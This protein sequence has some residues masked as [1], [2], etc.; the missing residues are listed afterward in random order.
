[1]TRF[2]AYASLAA[3]LVPA[4]VLAQCGVRHRAVKAVV[5]K[6][7]LVIAAPVVAVTPVAAFYAVPTL[8]GSIYYPGGTAPVVGAAGAGYGVHAAGPGVS[9]PAA[10]APPTAGLFSDGQKTWIRNE[11]RAAIAEALGKPPAAKGETLPPPMTKADEEPPAEA[12]GGKS[13][14]QVLVSNCLSCHQAGK[15]YR[16]VDEK[17][18]VVRETTFEMFEASGKQRAFTDR[19]WVKILAKTT[20]GLM[21]PPKKSPTTGEDE[22]SMSDKDAAIL[23][24]YIG[25]VIDAK[26]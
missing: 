1:M 20:T 10:P 8:V 18:K 2:L 7:Q 16:Q 13:G 12:K 17:G 14:P 4:P 9:Q 25:K 11:I 15:L 6:E 24:E 22:P 21:P 3:M 26:K 19:Q 23:A 5:V